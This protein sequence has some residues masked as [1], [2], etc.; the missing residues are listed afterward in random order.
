[1][2]IYAGLFEHGFMGAEIPA[3]YDG[4]CATFMMVNI[5]VE[6]LARVR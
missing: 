1:M 3:E 2:Q 6:E 5:I 4:P